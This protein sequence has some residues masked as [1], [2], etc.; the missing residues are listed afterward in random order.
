MSRDCQQLKQERLFMA[1]NLN[2]TGAKQ[3]AFNL[4]PV[5]PY[6]LDYFIPHSGVAEAV[7]IL[8][9]SIDFLQQNQGG[10]FFAFLHGARGVGKTHLSRAIIDLAKEQGIIAETLNL[11]EIKTELEFSEEQTR[12]IIDLYEQIR[13]SGGLCIF[14]SEC[15]SE[16]L[17]KDPHINSR[18]LAGMVCHMHYPKEVEIPAIIRSLAER[19]N[20]K[21]SEKNLEYILKRA[22]SSPLS[23]VAILDRISELS[24]SENRPANS[25]VVRQ[26]VSELME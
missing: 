18:I 13:A 23:F 26:V 22:K 11:S 5:Q 25:S 19:H 1:A 9:K 14:T 10:F 20:L 12:K 4:L 17:S 6:A 3:L 8:M 7:S 21:L 15:S 16:E 2:K 24:F